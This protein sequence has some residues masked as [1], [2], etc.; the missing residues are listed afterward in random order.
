MPLIEEIAKNTLRLYLLED[1]FIKD[2]HDN[3]DKHIFSNE[4]PYYNHSRKYLGVLL[5]INDFSYYAPL[6]SPKKSDYMNMKG[7]KIIRNSILPIIRMVETDKNGTR[8][9]LGTIKLSNMLPVPPSMLLNYDLDNET[10]AAYKALVLKEK[11][12]INRN[13]EMITAYA[14]SLYREKVTGISDKGYIANT[15]DFKALEEYITKKYPFNLTAT[16]NIGR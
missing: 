15:L 10:D 5:E 12:F 13:E 9:L 2:L 1:S 6:S 11:R 14:E 4:G 7:R 16:K 3:V 8:T